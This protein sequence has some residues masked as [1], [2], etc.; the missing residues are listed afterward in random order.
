MTLGASLTGGG[1]GDIH[2]ATGADGSQLVVKVR[3]AKSVSLER[4]SREIRT[5]IDLN[6]R[7]CALIPHVEGWLIDGE[8]AA[9]W[10][11]YYE[12]GTL[13]RRLDEDSVGE[14]LPR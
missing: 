8:F 5:M 6:E 3:K 7:G 10:M 4:F 13:Q 9:Y 1:Q 14:P 11:P 12:A 2:R